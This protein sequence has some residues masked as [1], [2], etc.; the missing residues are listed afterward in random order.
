MTYSRWRDSFWAT[1]EA[2]GAP[3]I[4]DSTLS[5]NPKVGDPKI[6]KFG[7]LN[8]LDLTEEWASSEFPDAPMHWLPE[9]LR[10]IHIY[11]DDMRHNVY[12]YK[13]YK[14][15]TAG[16]FY[17]ERDYRREFTDSRNEHKL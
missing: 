9:L 11:L 5:I 6:F 14:E 13:G 8:S 15:P 2:T 17:A 16:V 12:R 1:N 10:F 3:F 7:F 4:N